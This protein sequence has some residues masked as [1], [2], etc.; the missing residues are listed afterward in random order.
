MTESERYAAAWKEREGERLLRGG[1][2]EAALAAL[3]EAIRHDPELLSAY[4]SRAQ[5]HRYLGR[6]RE[7][8]LDYQRYWSTEATHRWRFSRVRRIK[9]WLGIHAADWQYTTPGKCAQVAICPL[10]DSKLG[11]ANGHIDDG[12]WHYL[13]DGS[14]AQMKKCRPCD[15]LFG[16]HRDPELHV[17]RQISNDYSDQVC[18]RCGEENNTPDW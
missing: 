5:V 16:S 13:A 4:R 15:D 2:Y 8:D 14:C 11:R 9:C 1:E 6:H 17:W 18:V 12:S 7:A 3:T 10:C